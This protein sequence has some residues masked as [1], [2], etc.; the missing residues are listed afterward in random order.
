MT[1]DPSIASP[2]NTAE[3]T[4]LQRALPLG[5]PPALVE[6]AVAALV[7]DDALRDALLGD[8]AEEFAARCAEHGAAPARAWYRAQVLGSVPHLLA[9]GWRRGD[10]G[11][12]A[13][14]AAALLTAVAGSYVAL[15]LM[16]QVAQLA[17]GLLLTRAASGAHAVTGS[18]FATCSTIAGCGAAV[19][20]GDLAGR[21]FPRAP[22]LAALTLAVVCGALAV[23]GMLIN[24]GVAPLWYWGALQ[25]VLLPLGACAG[26]LLRARARTPHR[27]PYAPRGSA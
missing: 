6:C 25:L 14:R 19:F 9:A 21:T 15:Q 3:R 24:A 10:G 18:A 2:E 5:G 1:S 11:R 16:H 23:T 13:R 7:A 22:L 26:G 12:P 20:G 17:I 4:F 27:A 8:L